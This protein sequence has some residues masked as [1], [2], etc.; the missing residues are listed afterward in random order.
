MS[1]ITNR[2]QKLEN[3][4]DGGLVTFIWIEEGETREAALF[5][6]QSETGKEPPKNIIFIRWGR[7]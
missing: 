6:W 3:K 7:K 1:S 5:R 4:A 2:V